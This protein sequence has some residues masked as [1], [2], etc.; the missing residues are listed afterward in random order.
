MS[1]TATQWGSAHL[2]ARLGLCM[3]KIPSR[4]SQ[5]AAIHGKLLHGDTA[6]GARDFAFIHAISFLE[7]F[8]DLAY[9]AVVIAA[10]GGGV[11]YNRARLATH[12]GALGPAED[13]CDVL[14]RF[15][16]RGLPM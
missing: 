12:R 6:E 7:A 5:C 13:D 3:S 16:E 11:D 15:A 1:A 9:E 10:D 14:V 8:A 2:P 4:S